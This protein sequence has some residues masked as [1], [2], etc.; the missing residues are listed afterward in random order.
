[1]RDL[2]ALRMLLFLFDEGSA[3]RVDVMDHLEAD[4]PTMTKTYN[5]LKAQG[6]AEMSYRLTPEG[7]KYAQGLRKSLGMDK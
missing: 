6:L 3:S 1:M 2:N 7:K 4:S 5:T